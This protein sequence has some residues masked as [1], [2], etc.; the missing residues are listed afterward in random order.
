[1]TNVAVAL[2]LQLEN[3][4]HNKSLDE[5]LVDNSSANSCRDDF[6]FLSINI[7]LVHSGESHR[8]TTSTFCIWKRLV[9]PFLFQFYQKMFTFLLKSYCVYC[10]RRLKT[11]ETLRF[12]FNFCS[13]CSHEHKMIIS[14]QNY[15][16]WWNS[17]KL[18]R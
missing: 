5:C 8:M 7:F 13:D 10:E 3:A 16:K 6:D 1:M 9:S 2:F 14:R 15:I 18:H 17:S 11:R 12:E 4:F